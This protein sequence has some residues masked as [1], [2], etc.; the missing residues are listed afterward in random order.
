MRS[1]RYLFIFILFIPISIVLALTDK[2]YIGGEN[3]GIDVKTNGILVVGLYKINNELIN[4][5]SNI[6]TGDYII[7]INNK[8]IYKIDDFIREIYDSEDKNNINIKLKR[9]NELI[10]THINVIYDDNEY[11]TGL[12]L[13]DNISGIGT[14]S[15]IDPNNNRFF[16]LGHQI[17]DINTNK[18]IDIS[19]GNIYYSYITSINRSD[20]GDIGEKNADTD[21][22]QTYGIINSNTKSGIFGEYTNNYTSKELFEVASIDEIKL[23]S[24]KIRTVTSGEDVKEYDINIDHID[25][26]DEYKNILF[27][28][29]DEELISKTGGIVQ[30]MSGSPIIQNNKLIGV[31]NYV[32]VN[33]CRKGYGIFAINMLKEAEKE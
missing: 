8:K 20:N 17:E 15:F 11:K 5:D 12:Y 26:K 22:N 19:S 30:G 32:I 10:D 9:N 23:G 18:I 2:V 6:S 14:L 25:K 31:I 4:K 13:K 28:V 27:S 29:T 21:P 16:A 3:I 1:F 7:E 33:D 24:A